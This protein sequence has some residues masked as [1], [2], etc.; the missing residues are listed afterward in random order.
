MTEFNYGEIKTRKFI[1]LFLSATRKKNYLFDQ[2]TR[3]YESAVD[4]DNKE[5]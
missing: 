5:N 3:K 4:I 2:G 1:N